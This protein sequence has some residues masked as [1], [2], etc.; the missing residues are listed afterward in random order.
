MFLP[1]VYYAYTLLYTPIHA[2]TYGRKNRI[3]QRGIKESVRLKEILSFALL[4][5][6][7]LMKDLEETFLGLSLQI[8][9]SVSS[10]STPTMPLCSKSEKH[11]ASYV[12]FARY[13]VFSNM[14]PFLEIRKFLKMLIV[15]SHPGKTIIFKICKKNVPLL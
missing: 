11:S 9:L 6:R 2:F 1:T 8:D 10:F 3:E 14:L 13:H 15:N 4:S 7:K 5:F 12:C